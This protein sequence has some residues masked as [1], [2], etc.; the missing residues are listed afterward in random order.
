MQGKQPPWPPSKVPASFSIFQSRRLLHAILFSYFVL[1][2]SCAVLHRVMLADA[3]VLA[4][5]SCRSIRMHALGAASA[6]RTR[7]F[8][9]PYDSAACRV[10]LLEL[11]YAAV[12]SLH[13]SQVLLLVLCCLGYGPLVLSC[14]EYSLR[15]YV[16]PG[17]R[18]RQLPS[19]Q[20]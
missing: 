13:A 7:P 6:L 16:R 1:L 4:P 14:S 3:H 18:S 11:L 8:A 5:L 9:A 12:F 20:T 17:H 15:N 19:W 10:A 2:T